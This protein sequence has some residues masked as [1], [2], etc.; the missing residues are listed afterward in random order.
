MDVEGEKG[1]GKIDDNMYSAQR[2]GAQTW[3]TSG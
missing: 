3:N 1:S 2:S